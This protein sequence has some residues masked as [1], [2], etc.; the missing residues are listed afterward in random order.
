MREISFDYDVNQTTIQRLLARHG[1]PRRGFGKVPGKPARWRKT[2]KEQASHIMKR[3]GLTFA[4]VDR[5]WVA[6]EGKCGICDVAIPR[7][8][9]K[10]MTIDHDHGT[11][12]V[13]GLL[14]NR[15]NRAIELF[16]DSVGLLRESARWIESHQLS[17]AEGPL[18]LKPN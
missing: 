5:M 7:R 17:N 14:C 1:V 13:R 8:Y 3:Y 15:C 18:T 4:D 11:G 16:E 9:G 10:G 6:Q 12:S 2:P